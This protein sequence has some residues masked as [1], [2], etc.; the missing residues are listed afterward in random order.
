MSQRG[1]GI[2]AKAIKKKKRVSSN[3]AHFEG[4]LEAFRI[5]LDEAVDTINRTTRRA[6][7]K[8]IKVQLRPCWS[9]TARSGSAP[10]VICSHAQEAVQQALAGGERR[11]G[12]VNGAAVGRTQPS[13]SQAAREDIEDNPFLTEHVYMQV[14]GLCVAHVPG[15]VCT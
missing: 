4:V 3:E 15:T 6:C 10:Y 7:R 9:A 1:I 12:P 11:T 2:N 5:G 13:R 14:G 8:A